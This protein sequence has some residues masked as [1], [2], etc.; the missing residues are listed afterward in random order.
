MKW[1]IFSMFNTIFNTII[2]KRITW[3]EIAWF[4]PLAIVFSYISSKLVNGYVRRTGR[5]S[6]ILILMV[7]ITVA[8]FGCVVYN[9]INGLIENAEKQIDFMP[10]C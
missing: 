10:I 1:L 6:I 4:V 2:S 9:L 3:I 7:F 5:Q 8:G